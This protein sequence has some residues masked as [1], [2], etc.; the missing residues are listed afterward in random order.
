MRPFMEQLSIFVDAIAEW[1][2][3]DIHQIGK[4]D[5]KENMQVEE[6]VQ[7]YIGSRLYGVQSV[8]DDSDN[9]KLGRE[10]EII[11]AQEII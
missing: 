10:T 5:S 8:T 4:Q 2:I 6:S 7:Y 11:I 3:A 1:D 9:V